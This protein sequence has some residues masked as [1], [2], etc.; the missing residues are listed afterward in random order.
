MGKHGT[1]FCIIAALALTLVASTAGASLLIDL[2]FADG[3]TNRNVSDPNGTA[4]VYVFARMIGTNIGAGSDDGLQQMFFSVKSRKVTGNV[5]AGGAGVGITSATISNGSPDGTNFISP[6]G[7]LPTVPA[8][9]SADSI[10]DLGGTTSNAQA[11]VAASGSTLLGGQV[12]SPAW[13]ANLTNSHAIT[14]GWE[15]YIGSFQVNWA[16]LAAGGVAG[17]KLAFD[18]SPNTSTTTASVWYENGGKLKYG[19]GAGTTGSYTAGTSVTFTLTPVPEPAT[20]V[21]L[22]LGGIGLAVKGLRRRV[23]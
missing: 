12:V 13:G 8:N 20:M 15:Y 10:Q 21:I 16:A 18:P 14:G 6:S 1:K 17:D 4:T 22:A 3:T 5:F 2:R 19:S 11:L 9:L 7:H 23:A